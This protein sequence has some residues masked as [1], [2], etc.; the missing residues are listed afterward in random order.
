MTTME[1]AS[2]DSTY[3]VVAVR[4]G[5]LPTSKDKHFKDD[6]V[7]GSPDAPLRLTESQS[8]LLGLQW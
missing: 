4:H 5:F 3:D 6:A 8:M 2:A 7:H 1:T